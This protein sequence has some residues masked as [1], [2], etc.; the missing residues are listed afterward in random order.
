[1]WVQREDRDAGRERGA[2]GNLEPEQHALQQDREEHDVRDV[3]RNVEYAKRP[4]RPDGVKMTC[5]AWAE[6]AISGWKPA[7][8]W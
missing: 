7:S 3:Q 6:A 4:R 8:R 5:A 1:M 2:T